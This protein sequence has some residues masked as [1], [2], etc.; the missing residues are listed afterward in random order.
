LRSEVDFRASHIIDDPA[1]N[2]ASDHR[3]VLAIFK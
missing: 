3:P 1:W 2:E